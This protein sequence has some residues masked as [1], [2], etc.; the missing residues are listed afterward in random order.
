LL[1]KFRRLG[2]S[3]IAPGPTRCDV[4]ARANKKVE[5]ERS[6]AKLQRRPVSVSDGTGSVLSDDAG[7]LEHEAKRARVDGMR[8]VIDKNKV[9]AINTQISVMRQ[10]GGCLR[11][12]NG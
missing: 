1:Q 12:Q 5:K 10:L 3:S 9:E 2:G 11:Q 8:S 7:V 4:R 6:A